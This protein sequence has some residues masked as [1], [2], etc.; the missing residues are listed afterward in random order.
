MKNVLS[1][2]KREFPFVHSRSATEGDFYD[3]CVDHNIQVVFDFNVRTGIYVVV[4]GEHYIFL[5]NKLKG[6]FLL[7]VMFHELAHYIF[8]QPT[9]TNFGAE[10]FDHHTKEKN[11]KEAEAVAAYLLL[12]PREIENAL[13][14]GVHLRDERAANLIGLR[15]DLASKYKK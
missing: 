14:E 9:Q 13:I 1:R 7:Y 3:Y 2:L 8:H 15:M 11:H 10:F 5:N 4:D 6:W 12:P